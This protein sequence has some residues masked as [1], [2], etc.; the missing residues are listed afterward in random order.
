MAPGVATFGQGSGPILL[1]ELNC[2]GTEARLVDCSHNGLNTHNCA[3]TEDAG[4]VCQRKCFL[5]LLISCQ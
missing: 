3:H 1:D 4:A 2:G 5:A